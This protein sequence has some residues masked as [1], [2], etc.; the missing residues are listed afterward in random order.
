MTIVTLSAAGAASPDEA[1]DR[2]AHLARWSQWA[3]QI[4]R[5]ECDEARLVTGMTGRVIGPLGV[6]VNFVVDAVDHI[7]RTWAW[8]VHVGPI[9]LELH[10]SVRSDPR[11][12][13]TNLRVEGPLA[14]VVPYAPLARYALSRLV[15]A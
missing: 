13:A 9:Q 6:G 11:G 10:H 14:V 5:V 2:Y 4:T 12:C 1:W 8:T 7:G 15:A 3:P